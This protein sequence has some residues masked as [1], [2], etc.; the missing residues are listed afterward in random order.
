[1]KIVTLLIIIMIT[2]RKFVEL[3]SWATSKNY[4]LLLMHY[5]KNQL[6][7]LTFGVSSALIKSVWVL[8]TTLPYSGVDDPLNCFKDG[9]EIH[10][11]T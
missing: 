1:M 11:V 7:I 5:K 8:L 6:L 3:A 4:R 10:Q 9:G 2:V